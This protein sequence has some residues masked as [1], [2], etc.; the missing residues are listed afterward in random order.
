M[1]HAR[2]LTVGCLLLLLL[3]GCGSGSPAAPAALESPP[4]LAETPP[5]EPAGPCA[6]GGA[7][8]ERDLQLA[9][10]A[11]LGQ[12]LSPLGGAVR[13]TLPVDR[14]LLDAVLDVDSADGTAVSAWLQRLQVGRNGPFAVSQGGGRFWRFAPADA[15]S[16]V[17]TMRMQGASPAWTRLLG[18]SLGPERFQV[19]LHYRPAVPLAAGAGFAE[20]V[21]SLL[22]AVRRGDPMTAQATGIY[23]QGLG[24]APDPLLRGAHDLAPVAQTLL[25]KAQ[26]E[27]PGRRQ[28]V[29]GVLRILD[30]R[31][32]A[33]V[34]GVLLD[35]GGGRA[36]GFVA[37]SADSDQ[38]LVT[39]QEQDGV[40]FEW[41]YQLQDLVD[42]PPADPAAAPVAPGWPQGRDGYGRAVRAALGV[43]RRMGNG[44]PGDSLRQRLLWAP[45]ASRE[46]VYPTAGQLYDEAIRYVG[47]QG[48]DRLAFQVQ[49]IFEDTLCTYAV[50]L[51]RQ[52]GVAGFRHDPADG[53]PACSRTG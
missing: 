44:A 17:L 45:G 32:L 23:L 39:V 52:G 9:A 33:L 26:G 24:P 43:M 29:A 16:V 3:A 20:Y 34:P 27:C 48:D 31:S 41:F 12:E 25:A 11:R 36:V 10:A 15:G 18:A 46:G 14:R 19:E 53:G 22:A 28:R 5:V 21:E 6:P 37:A 4:P 13:R 49:S 1:R 30:Q 35:A 2:R 51:A 42:P 38:A 7:W 40:R 8:L 50:V 47:P